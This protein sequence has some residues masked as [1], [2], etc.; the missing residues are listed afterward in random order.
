MLFHQIL[1]KQRDFTIVGENGG[2]IYYR[3]ATK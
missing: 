2:N 3:N 1:I